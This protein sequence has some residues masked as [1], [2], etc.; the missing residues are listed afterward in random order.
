[1]CGPAAT[2]PK[3][4]GLVGDIEKFGKQWAGVRLAHEAMMVEDARDLLRRNRGNTYTEGATP[5]S[6]VSPDP[7][8][9]EAM[10]IGDI[11]NNFV[12]SR[13]TQ[14]RHEQEIA[15]LKNQYEGQMQAQQAAFESR[16][17][18]LEA[19]IQK[20]TIDQPVKD[21]GL[22]Q[23]PSPVRSNESIPGVV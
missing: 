23:V 8:E 10:H 4:V 5:D 15:N 21:A 7:G 18:A 12:D 6:Q 13:E 9:S 1:M 2:Y 17:A 11:N 22:T 3:D 20:K 14:V 19:S 16:L